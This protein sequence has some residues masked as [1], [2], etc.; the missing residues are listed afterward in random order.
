[1][2]II[3]LLLGGGM[4]AIGR[5]LLTEFLVNRSKSDSFPTAILIINLLGSFGLGLFLGMVGAESNSTV[6]LMISVGFFGAF[7]TF[8][9]FS[10][11]VIELIKARKWR[12]AL[13]YLTVTI[14]G[15]ICV[16]LLGISII[17]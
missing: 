5:Y 15:S 1:M 10:M 17:K 12:S 7:T 8:S 2:K 14:F 6:S 9:T 3:L 16:C 13:L 4:G 11:E